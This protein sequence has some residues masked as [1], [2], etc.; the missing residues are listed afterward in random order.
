M[1]TRYIKVSGDTATPLPDRL[2]DMSTHSLDLTD[3]QYASHVGPHYFKVVDGEPVAKS[4]VEVQE[5]IDAAVK[6]NKLNELKAQLKEELEANVV[7]VRPGVF[8]KAREA[9]YVNIKL[10]HDSLEAGEVYPDWHQ[11]DQVFDLTKEELGKVLADGPAQAV[12]LHQA[13]SLRI[14]EL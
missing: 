3:E 2:V 6:A 14:K 13:H 1:K 9:D 5:M 12:L 11:G 7:E 8:V 4:A 10:A